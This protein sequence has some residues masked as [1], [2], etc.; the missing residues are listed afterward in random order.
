M[1]PRLN[2]QSVL[3]AIVGAAAAATT[4]AT[5]LALPDQP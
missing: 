4:L 5:T 2:T 3:L 1:T